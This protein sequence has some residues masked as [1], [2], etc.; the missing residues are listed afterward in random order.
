[1]QQYNSNN[2]TW[3][4]DSLKAFDNHKRRTNTRN[5]SSCLQVTVAVHSR[6]H[7]RDSTSTLTYQSPTDRCHCCNSTEPGECN[8]E[9]I[10]FTLCSIIKNNLIVRN[11]IPCFGTCNIGH[12]WQNFIRLQTSDSQQFIG[13]SSISPARTIVAQLQS[14]MLTKYRHECTNF[15]HTN[16]IF[17]NHNWRNS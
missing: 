1:M 12:S 11:K 2:T 8:W 7:Q 3:F 16:R 9:Y 14:D 4:R 17:H 13:Q 15:F 6:W 10:P 5:N